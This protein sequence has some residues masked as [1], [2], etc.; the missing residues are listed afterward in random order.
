MTPVAK[1][2]DVPNFG[3]KVVPV[4]GKEILLVNIKGVLHA[5]ENE[6]PHHGSPLGAAVIKDGY[7]ACPRHGYRFSL[8]DGKCS[9]HPDFTLKI[10][11][12][13][14]QGDNILVDLGL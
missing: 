8:L 10:Y 5:C 4:S 14:L 6:C 11:P 7:L 3:K 9:E 2:S 12:V 13:E 1:I